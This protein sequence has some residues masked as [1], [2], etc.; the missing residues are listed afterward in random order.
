LEPNFGIILLISVSFGCGTKRERFRGGGGGVQ[1]MRVYTCMR[2]YVRVCVY[3]C[4]CVRVYVYASVCSWYACMR[5]YVY[6]C[7]R[8]YVLCETLHIRI[9]ICISSLPSTSAGSPRVS[10]SQAPPHPPPAA[11]AGSYPPVAVRNECCSSAL[12][13]ILRL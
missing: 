13:P 3:V 4:V 1:H 5:V 2:V 10:K 8:M 7:M 9:S 6:A 12:V 11:V